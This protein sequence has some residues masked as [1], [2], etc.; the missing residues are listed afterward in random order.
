LIDQA[1]KALSEGRF[2]LFVSE[3]ECEKKLEKITHCGYLYHS[4]KSFSKTME[5]VNREAAIAYLPLEFRLQTMM[6]ISLK[7]SL[8]ERL[9]AFM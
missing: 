9:S 5:V 1:R 7:K 8:R 6:T 3:G 2:P 4:Y